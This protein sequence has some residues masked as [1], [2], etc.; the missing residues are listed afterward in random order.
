MQA[1]SHEKGTTL[2][3]GDQE[4]SC[5]GWSRPLRRYGDRHEKAGDCATRSLHR[6]SYRAS[7]FIFAW[8][9]EEKRSRRAARRR[10]VRR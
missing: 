2:A 3:F 7:Q 8:P 6:P 9:L 1:A 5:G 10:V 4:A